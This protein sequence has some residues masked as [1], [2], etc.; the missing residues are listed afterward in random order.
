MNEIREVFSKIRATEELK[1]NTLQYLLKQQ[2][3]RSGFRRRPAFLYALAAICVFLLSGAGGYSIYMQPVSYISIDV[4]PSVELGVNRFGRVVSANAYNED[5]QA[6]LRQLSLNNIPYV[7]AISTLLAKES[8]S[9][10]LKEDSLLV[11]TV[12][13]AQYTSIMEDLRDAEFFQKYGALLYT[14]DSDCMKEAHSHEMSFGKYRGYLELSQYDSSVTIG[15]C[16]DMT[17]EELHDRIESCSGHQGGSGSH[18]HKPPQT[19]T[20]DPMATSTPESTGTG[21]HG[22]HGNHH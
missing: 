6:I 2:E 13:S 11:F 5:G 15:D 14:S 17:M 12:I 9:G 7:Q 3:K 21:H 4:N 16:H 22:G 18:H 8:S 19:E 10:F 20:T 1:Q